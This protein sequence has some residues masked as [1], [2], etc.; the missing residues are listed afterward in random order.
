[1]SKASPDLRLLDDVVAPRVLG[2]MRSASRALA[3]LG[4]RQYLV[5]NAPSLVAKL[6]ECIALARAE[7]E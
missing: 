7:E 2:A 3:A 5:R 6:D 1:M 4:V